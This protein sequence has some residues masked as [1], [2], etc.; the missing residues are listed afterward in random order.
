MCCLAG[1]AWGELIERSLFFQS[2]GGVFACQEGL[3]HEFSC[4][5]KPGRTTQ[6][7]VLDLLRKRRG[8]L[9]RELVLSPDAHGLG[10]I[11]HRLQPDQVTRSV[12]GFCSIGCSLDV[13]LARQGTAIN[14]S[15]SRNYPVNLGTACPKGWESLAVLD[16]PDRAVAPLVKDRQGQLHP[17]DWDTALKT[18]VNRVREIQQRH[19]PH[20]VAFLSTG[21][22]P[23]EE[24]ALL[25]ALAKFGMGMIHGDGNTRQCMASAVVAYKESFGFDAPPYTYQDLEESDVMVFVGA[26]PCIAHP[27]LWHRVLRNPHRPQIIVV[28]PRRTETAMAATTHLPLKP[29]SDL[30]LFYGLANILIVNGWIDRP[31]IDAHTSGFDQFAALCRSVTIPSASPRRPASPSK[32]CTKWPARFMKGS[33]FRSGGRWESIRATKA[34]ARPRA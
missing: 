6:Q 19:G 25:G 14:L 20:S 33:E 8:R 16:A 13:H 17:V 26:N 5:D 18:F 29:K 15:P 7:T 11:P 30:E 23:S 4:F 32:R 22:I 12:C 3:R 10:Q 34:C 28:D 24:M 27:I 1:L 31:F 2:V 21:Q 9:T